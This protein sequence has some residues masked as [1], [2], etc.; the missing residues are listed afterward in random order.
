MGRNEYIDEQGSVGLI[1]Y[2]FLS[3]KFILVAKLSHLLWT[4]NKA[5]NVWYEI[6]LRIILENCYIH[7]YVK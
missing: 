7:V 5:L 2:N 6:M 3:Y 1:A 4:I